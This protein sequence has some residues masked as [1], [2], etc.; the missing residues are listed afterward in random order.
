MCDHYCR[1]RHCLSST[2]ERDTFQRTFEIKSRYSQ[3][4][5]L[6]SMVVL[7]YSKTIRIKRT[8]NYQSQTDLPRG[9]REVC[10]CSYNFLIFTQLLLQTPI[11]LNDCESIEIVDE[12]EQTDDNGYTFQQMSSQQ[13]ILKDYGRKNRV[14]FADVLSCPDEDETSRLLVETVN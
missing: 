14:G 9:V 4:L 8:S 2:G 13:Y 3:I 5:I 10:L 1:G 11:L 7:M 6:I 12:C